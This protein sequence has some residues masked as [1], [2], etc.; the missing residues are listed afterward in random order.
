MNFKL[1]LLFFKVKA[2]LYR[3]ERAVRS[4]FHGDPI[5]KEMDQALKKSYRRVNPYRLSNQFLISQGSDERDVYG[6]TP[7]TTLQKIA[8]ELELTP[9]D[10]LFELGCGRGR[11]VFFLRC[12]FGCT[13][14]GIDWHPT[15][16]S[17]AQKIAELDSN[18]KTHFICSNF[19]K[20]DLS[21]ATAIY[22]YGTCLKDEEIYALAHRLAQ[23]TLLKRILTVSFPL[24][25]YSPDFRTL[26]VFTASFPWGDADLFVNLRS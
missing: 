5:F 12:I 3:E 16:I 25:D 23:C 8:T 24:S 1:W 10:H 11:G 9:E 18:D 20:A 4:L 14:T 13:V 2:Y 19:A 26:K 6:E 7:L 17:I 21:K 15:F 22:L